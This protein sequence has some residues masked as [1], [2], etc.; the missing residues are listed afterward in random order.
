L[1]KQPQDFWDGLGS[2]WDD[3]ED[4]QLI[5]KYWEGMLTT[6]TESS[7]YL[8]QQ[9]L[10]RFPQFNSDIWEHKY[11]SFPIIWHGDES[12]EIAKTKTFPILDQY[13]GIF[14]IPL[15]HGAESDQYMVE[16]IDYKIVDSNKIQFLNQYPNPD[17][18]I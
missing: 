4:R 6:F 7:M 17:P 11:L 13:H 3:F 12:N 18:R 9:F 14:S 8:Y 5:E 16:N 10:L 15:L 1:A 2:F